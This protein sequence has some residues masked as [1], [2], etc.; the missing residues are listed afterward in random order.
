MK[1]HYSYCIPVL[2]GRAVRALSW[3]PIGECEK[4]AVLTQ[5]SFDIDRR[6][7]E[8]PSLKED[9]LFEWSLVVRCDDDLRAPGIPFN[10]NT[11]VTGVKVTLTPMVKEEE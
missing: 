11:E 3:H 5:V 10:I 2:D 1:Q 8:E 6:L 9:L 4:D 7:Q